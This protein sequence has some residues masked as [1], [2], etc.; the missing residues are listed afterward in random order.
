MSQSL[1][2]SGR[3]FQIPVEVAIDLAGSRRRNPFTDQVVCFTNGI[4]G[5]YITPKGVLSQ[6]LHRS[7]RLFRC[8]SEND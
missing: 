6:S 7:G 4:F 1:H 5:C 3:L 8:P 2:R